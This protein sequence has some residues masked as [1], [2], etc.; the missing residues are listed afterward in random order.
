M[1]LGVALALR[2]AVVL[3]THDHVPVGDAA[4][5]LRN[6]YVLDAFDRFPT[7]AIGA[8]ETATALRPP[9]YPLVMAGVFKVFGFHLTPVR[10]LGALLGTLTVWLVFDIARRVFDDRTA[11]IAAAIAAIF[12]PLVWLSASLLSENLFLPLVLAAAACLLRV[13]GSPRATWWALAAGG[14]LGAA[15]MT[16]GNGILLAIPMVVATLPRARPTIAAALALLV[17]LVPWTVRNAGEFDRFLPLGTQSGYTLAGAYNS[18]A[19]KPDRFQAAWRN[20]E[21][22]P[23]YAPLFHKP[24]IDEGDLDAALRH[25]ARRFATDHPGYVL[26][27]LRLNALRLLDLGPGHTFVSGVSYTEMAIPRA[28]RWSL[29]VG[30]YLTLA[31]ALAGA[32]LVI[33]DRRGPLW[34]WLFPLLLFASV[35]VVLGA[36]RY[37]APVDPFLVMLAAYARGLVHVA[38]AVPIP[39]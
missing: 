7:T 6:G 30:L 29:R 27:V 9:A 10:L 21:T 18:S 20:P 1:I 3:G 23:D 8:P 31:L 35:V 24:G 28:W 11:L 37:R 16:R 17:V 39:D 2:V 22:T 32:V 33:R 38:H 25:D 19:E 26:T 14:L 5:Y 13:R 12:P 15:V 36:P 4:D 34:L